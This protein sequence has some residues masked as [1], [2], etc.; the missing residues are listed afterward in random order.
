MLNRNI[1]FAVAATVAA[2]AFA[3]TPVVAPSTAASVAPRP[4]PNCVKPEQPGRLATNNQFK[5]F[6]SEV[7]AYRDCMQAFAK[8]Q[9]DLAKLHAEIG[10]SAIK[11]YNDYILELNK[12]KDEEAAKK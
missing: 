10:N 8:T 7:N 1:I 4:A 11:E 6:G 12:T 2:P 9:G 3:Q 5:T